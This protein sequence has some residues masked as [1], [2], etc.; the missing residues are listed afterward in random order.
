[1]KKWFLL[2]GIAL[3]SADITPWHVELPALVIADFA[4]PGLSFSN[5][6]AVSAGEAA[7]AIA[8]NRFPQP[9]FA[10]VL[11]QNVAEGR[12]LLLF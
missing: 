5:G 11:V 4:N 1:M 6:T 12:H 9:T 7:N 2:D 10:D 3:H 8:L